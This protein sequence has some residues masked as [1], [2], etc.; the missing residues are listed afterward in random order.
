MNVRK[1][2][3]AKCQKLKEFIEFFW[4]RVL[5]GDKGSPEYKIVVSHANH[6]KWIP[7]NYDLFMSIPLYDNDNDDS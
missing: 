1:K 6:K 2:I 5:P 4:M 3:K 7:A